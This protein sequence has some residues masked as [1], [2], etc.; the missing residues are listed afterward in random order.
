MQ[1]FKSVLSAVTSFALAFSPA[2]AQ[3]ERSE[4][5]A[6]AP[7]AETAPAAESEPAAETAKPV[8]KSKDP[9]DETGAPPKGTGKLVGGIVAS[10]VG[11][12]LGLLLIAVGNI[13][14]DDIDKDNAETT[15]ETKRAEREKQVK[16][17]KRDQ[18]NIR[19]SG[20][21]VLVGGLGVG[22]P[23]MYFGIKDRK[24]YNEWKEQ[25][26]PQ[27]TALPGTASLIVMRTRDASFA[28]GLGLSYEF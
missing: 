9:I 7:A 3:E 27:Q 23:L 24:A 19:T 20:T 14:C 21:V 22:L 15:D 10:S 26:Q 17:C 11:V 16:D 13:D 5:T 18:P 4:E 8:K 2:L 25:Q 1:M 6:P 28:P 12:G